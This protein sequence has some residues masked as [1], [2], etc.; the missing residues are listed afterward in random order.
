MEKPRILI[1]ED[2]N[3]IAALLRTILTAHGYSICGAI[4]TDENVADVVRATHPDLVLMDVI[5]DGKV[6]GAVAAEHINMVANIPIILVSD[7]PC[8]S[9]KVQRLRQSGYLAKPFKMKELLHVVEKA[10]AGDNLC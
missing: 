9:A 3:S 10:L 5:L 4:A 6:D 2:E 1:V 7:Y 8:H